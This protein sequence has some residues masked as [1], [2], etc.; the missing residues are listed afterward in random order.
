[1]RTQKL[2]IIINTFKVSVSIHLFTTYM[3]FFRLVVLIFFSCVVCIGCKRE[4]TEPIALPIESPSC[5]SLGIPLTG[6]EFDMQYITSSPKFEMP[7]FNP[8]NDTEFIYRSGSKLW[9]YNL[10]SRDTELLIDNVRLFSQPTWSRSGHIAFTQAD[11]NIWLMDE[12]GNGLIQLSDGGKD[13]F[14]EFL[15]NRDE[16]LF[17]K[18]GSILITDLESNLIT[19]FCKQYEDSLCNAWRMSSSST[20]G[21]IACEYIPNQD[22][23]GVAIYD[24]EGNLEQV[25]YKTKQ[26]P[27]SDE[28]ILDIDWH[29][30]DLTVFFTDGRGIHS[31]NIETSEKSL[32]NEACESKNY[33]DISISPD[34]NTLIATRLTSSYA[35]CLVTSKMSIVRM[36][37]DGSNEE[38]LLTP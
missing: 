30:N 11:L 20:N 2:K 19:K 26:R 13:L 17:T 4:P 34:G 31:V 32:V 29:P 8:N 27:E 18:G 21:E 14:P 15:S 28:L 9:K 22:E 35:D 16:L 38:E 24:L 12:N 25:I 5:R 6:C 3:I 23:Y 10:T 7:C 1:M 37:I 36:D 33:R